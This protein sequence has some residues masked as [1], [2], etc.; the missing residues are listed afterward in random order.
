[1]TSEKPTQEDPYAVMQEA[2]TSETDTPTPSGAEETPVPEDGGE[3]IVEDA[4][5]GRM[6][7]IED[8]KQAELE[9]FKAGVLDRTSAFRDRAGE[10]LSRA[11]GSIKG[12]AWRGLF[13]AHKG[14]QAVG[15]SIVETKQGFID[16]GTA[17][18]EAAIAGGQVV[19][20][21]V[22]TVKTRTIEGFNADLEAGRAVV[23]AGKE[24]A[25]QAKEYT[26]EG[27]KAVGVGAKE[28]GL[29][30]VGAGILAAEK[31]G[32]GINATVEL[33][34]RGVAAGKEFVE[35]GIAKAEQAREAARERIV[36]AKTATVEAVSS[37]ANAAKEKTVETVI[38][39]KEAV[40]NGVMRVAEA[41]NAVKE[42]A[43]EGVKSAW[44]KMKEKKNAVKRGLLM[45]KL[46]FFESQHERASEAANAKLQK[47]NEI[48]AALAAI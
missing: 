29:F 8:P 9:E 15:E 4:A 46:A 6:G 21:G 18:K 25:E 48:R 30:A 23:E 31:V 36:S 37:V 1:M 22:E 5:E 43:T 10:L 3:N 47:A 28:A 35:T 7:V 16:M 32:Q 38:A 45:A 13:G 26:I 44:E 39:G 27:A 12:A 34:E 2:Q 19:T 14:A 40:Q 11:G 41:G 24:K 42:R 20:S 17:A 33:G